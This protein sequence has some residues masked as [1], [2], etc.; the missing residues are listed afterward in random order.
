MHEK[1]GLTAKLSLLE[2]PLLVNNRDYGII[3]PERA[4]KTGRGK[5][6]KRGLIMYD[7]P[8]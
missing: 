8:P 7:Q 4:T 3:D 1:R 5:Q 6:S 2:S